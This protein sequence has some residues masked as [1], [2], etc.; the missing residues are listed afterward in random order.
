MNTG[1]YTNKRVGVA[2]LDSKNELVLIKRGHPPVQGLWTLPMGHVENNETLQK[3]AVRELLEETNLHAVLEAQLGVY[4][5]DGVEL[6]VFLGRIVGG[7]LRAGDDAEEARLISLDV[8]RHGIPGND[9][10]AYSER[11]VYEVH[12]EIFGDLLARHFSQ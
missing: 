5:V 6:T 4:K 3:A 9:E 2:A 1:H 7:R 8:I 10:A 12:K 11:E